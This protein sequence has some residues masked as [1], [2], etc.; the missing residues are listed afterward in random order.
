MPYKIK[1]AHL[2]AHPKIKLHIKTRR[3]KN[4]APASRKAIQRI[5]TTKQKR[6]NNERKKRKQ[7]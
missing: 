5:Q 2:N 3:A 4:T 7:T 6:R 1:G